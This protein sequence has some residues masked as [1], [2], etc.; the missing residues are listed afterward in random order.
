MRLIL[1]LIQSLIVTMLWWLLLAVIVGVQCRRY[2]IHEYSSFK[3]Q[4]VTRCQQWGANIVFGVTLRKSYHKGPRHFELLHSH[5]NPHVEPATC[6]LEHHTY[7]L[8]T[9]HIV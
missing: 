3:V 1:V 9:N 2:L 5:A 6:A 7:L 4:N 8:L